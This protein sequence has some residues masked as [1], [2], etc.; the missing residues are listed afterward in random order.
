MKRRN[1][2]RSIALGT[3][4]ALAPILLNTPRLVLPPMINWRHWPGG[5]HDDH[6]ESL[7]YWRDLYWPEL[8]LPSTV[9]IQTRWHQDDLYSRL[10]TAQ[11]FNRGS[12][13]H[14]ICYR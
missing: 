2:L 9:I 12:L 7:D 5:D 13:F 8:S 10:I 4:V 6:V 11:E 3:A 1:F 14:D